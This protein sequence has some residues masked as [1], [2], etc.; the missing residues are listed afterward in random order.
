MIRF[1]SLFACIALS[2]AVAP[3]FAEDVTPP[4]NSTL[5]GVDK[6]YRIVKPQAPEPDEPAV[7][8]PGQFKIGDMDVHISGN[9]TVDI[10]A[11][12]LQPRGRR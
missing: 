10:G 3:A 4:A 5:P 6:P 7:K 2:A 1:L 11:G 12:P 9:V 8:T